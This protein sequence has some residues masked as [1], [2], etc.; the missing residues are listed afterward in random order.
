MELA[1]LSHNNTSGKCRQDQPPPNIAE[2]AVLRTANRTV[3][4]EASHH[5]SWLP[6]QVGKDANTLL[7]RCCQADNAKTETNVTPN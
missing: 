3:T 4:S 1:G 2:T 6:S 7:A 5:R